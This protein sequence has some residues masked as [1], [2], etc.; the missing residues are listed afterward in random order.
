MPHLQAEGNILAD[1]QVRKESVILK[2]Q[3][4]VPQ[5]KI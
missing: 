5:M 4:E 1:I 3:A 2:D